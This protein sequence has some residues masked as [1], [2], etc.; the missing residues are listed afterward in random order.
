LGEGWGVCEAASFSTSFV[1]R[2]AS[3]YGHLLAAWP[4]GAGPQ[5]SLALLSGDIAGQLR[6]VAERFGIDTF[7]LSLSSRTEDVEAGLPYLLLYDLERGLRVP[8]KEAETPLMPKHA[9][10][11]GYAPLD[12][13]EKERFLAL[14]KRQQEEAPTEKA[15]ADLQ[16]WQR[17][18]SHTLA[19]AQADAAMS[20]EGQTA[21]M[22]LLKQGRMFQGAL[23]VAGSRTA[24][25]ADKVGMKAETQKMRA[26]LVKQ[27]SN[28]A[29]PEAV[30]AA[31]RLSLKQLDKASAEKPLAWK[32]K[33]LEGKRIGA[34]VLS[35][36]RQGIVNTFP[37][38]PILGATLSFLKTD[39]AIIKGQSAGMM[40][41]AQ[42]NERLGKEPKGRYAPVAQKPATRQQ[43]S[44][45]L[46]Q[47]N[48]ARKAVKQNMTSKGET[49]VFVARAS[50]Q[51]PAS[52]S[53][54]A[55]NPVSTA[56][57][58]QTK[59][60]QAETRLQ[61][62]PHVA[63]APM[64]KI[65]IPLGRNDV[66][67]TLNGRSSTPKV[68]AFPVE[69]RDA[70]SSSQQVNSPSLDR[71]VS[72]AQSFPIQGSGISETSQAQRAVSQGKAVS[73]ASEVSKVKSDLPPNEKKPPARAQK[74]ARTVPPEH[75][76]E[77]QEL[78]NAPPQTLETQKA[79]SE[80]SP[81]K[82][83]QPK[84]DKAKLK[85]KFRSACSECTHHD[86]SNCAL[87]GGTNRSALD[88][89]KG[90]AAQEKKSPS[91][92]SQEALA[93]TAKQQ[94]SDEKTKEMKKDFKNAANAC[95]GCTGGN[96]ATCPKGGGLN[97][98]AL[99]LISALA[100]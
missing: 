92:S 78:A 81:Q 32:P 50:S 70:K 55:D 6:P 73:G 38:A 61:N 15:I 10:W 44:M 65:A 19:L 23:L 62:V 99:N 89:I 41:A 86:C 7:G 1:T 8:M 77:K 60:T 40:R 67:V 69:L 57:G 9:L 74:K 25:A 53:F 84:A 87:G 93:N 5:E 27:L 4:E 72:K 26:A 54:V 35:V 31:L 13:E 83:E 100:V 20:M 58:A 34:S 18:F 71:A 82:R 14:E 85:T 51:S 12:E 75:R 45:V 79:K 48:L 46:Q 63:A 33:S 22:G 16:A 98:A 90:L 28:T 96:C 49:P 2:L 88:A 94:A 21:L 52:R 43:A 80:T 30:R 24:K 42:Q 29:L 17:G 59:I 97:R 39:T 68:T 76:A 3:V 11:V 91:S 47:G 37:K 36:P 66:A 64:K 95:A 56:V